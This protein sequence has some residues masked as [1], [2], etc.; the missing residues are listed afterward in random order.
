MFENQMSHPLPDWKKFPY[1]QNVAWG[2]LKIEK[3][4]KDVTLAVLIAI[5]SLFL[6]FTTQFATSHKCKIAGSLISS[7]KTLKESMV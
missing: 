2:H 7:L 5:T 1:G 3:S 4:A 6:E